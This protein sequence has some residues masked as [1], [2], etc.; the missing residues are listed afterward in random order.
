MSRWVTAYEGG[1][2]GGNHHQQAFITPEERL[3]SLSMESAVLQMEGNLTALI[4]C[5]VQC[6]A[7]ARL[8]YPK[9]HLKYVECQSSLAQAYMLSGLPLQAVEHASIALEVAEERNEKEL[10]MVLCLTLGRACS[11]LGEH[12][13][14]LLY[15]NNAKQLVKA[16]DGDDA[17]MQVPI[18]N[19]QAEVYSMQGDHDAAISTLIQ[20]WTVCEAVLG[21]THLDVAEAHLELGRSYHAK[22]IHA[23]TV[24][25]I[26]DALAI[27]SLH[28][29]ILI[30]PAFSSGSSEVNMKANLSIGG[31]LCLLVSVYLKPNQGAFEDGSEDKDFKACVN[32]FLDAI[33]IYAHLAS[34]RD[35]HVNAELSGACI[36]KLIW[37]RWE[38][39]TLYE[40]AED[41]DNA[42]EQLQLVLWAQEERGNGVTSSRC[43]YG[44]SCVC[45]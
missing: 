45:E 26:N 27:V 29:S 36:N 31:A 12:F 42:I 44:A 15:L 23:K 3:A 17:L 37:L 25:H 4:A 20:V 7:L 40:K 9:S 6:L 32:C 10:I 2:M 11:A 13:Q 14:A 35:E 33:R 18:L 41:F 43:V 28:D 1:E 5:R 16:F 24:Q 8:C 34:L 21:Q 19:S 22:G 38:L 30:S 39:A